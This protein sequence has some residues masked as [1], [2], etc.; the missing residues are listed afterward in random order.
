MSLLNPRFFKIAFWAAFVLRVSADASNSTNNTLL[1]LVFACRYSDDVCCETYAGAA[2]VAARHAN[3]GNGVLV[4]QFANRSAL[5]TM[6]LEIRTQDRNQYTNAYDLMKAV[7]TSTGGTSAQQQHGIIGFDFTSDVVGAHKYLVEVSDTKTPLIGW[8]AAGP[9]FAKKPLWYQSFYSMYPNDALVAQQMAELFVLK[10][11]WSYFACISEDDP[12]SSGFME[13]FSETVNG[14]ISTGDVKIPGKPAGA[15]ERYVLDHS[16]TEKNS[17]AVLQ[18]LRSRVPR[19]IVY[20][21]LNSLG[22]RTFLQAAASLNMAGREAVGG[23]SLVSV[24]LGSEGQTW[25]QNDEYYGLFTLQPQALDTTK[26]AQLRTLWPSEMSAGPLPGAP[27]G[28]SKGGATGLDIEDRQVLRPACEAYVGYVYDAVAAA[29]LAAGAQ[30]VNSTGSG[31]TGIDLSAA[32]ANGVLFDGITGRVHRKSPTSTTSGATVQKNWPLRDDISF[33][34]LNVLPETSAASNTASTTSSSGPLKITRVLTFNKASTVTVDREGSYLHRAAVDTAR[35]LD[36]PA[37]PTLKMTTIASPGREVALHSSHVEG[38]CFSSQVYCGSHGRCMNTPTLGLAAAH[39]E[40]DKGYV[41]RL[42]DMKSRSMDEMKMAPGI[43]NRVPIYVEINWDEFEHFDEKDFAGAIFVEQW[44]YDARTR[45][46]DGTWAGVTLRTLHERELIWL[47]RVVGV[48]PCSSVETANVFTAEVKYPIVR[49]AQKLRVSG[50]AVTP[51]WD[52]YPFDTQRPSITIPTAGSDVLWIGNS[53]TTVV[54]AVTGISSTVSGWQ[55]WLDTHLPTWIQAEGASKSEQQAEAAKLVA[56]GENARNVSMTHL[57]G[58]VGK[59]FTLPGVPDEVLAMRWSSTWPVEK[60]TISYSAEGTDAILGVVITRRGELWVFRMAIPAILLGT[61]AF[62]TFIV[63]HNILVPRFMSGFLAF[64]A[65]TALRKAAVDEAPESM[66][67]MNYLDV[68]LLYLTLV[69]AGGVIAV[70]VGEYLQQKY[71]SIICIEADSM[72]RRCVPPC[73]SVAVT[74]LALCAGEDNTLGITDVSTIQFVALF[75]AFTPATIWLIWVTLIVINAD[76]FFLYRAIET[77]ES[78]SASV[79]LLKERELR[80]YFQWMYEAVG[81]PPKVGRKKNGLASLQKE[82][83]TTSSSKLSKNFLNTGKMLK[84]TVGGGGFQETNGATRADAVS[85]ATGEAADDGQQTLPPIEVPST[86]RTNQ[87]QGGDPSNEPPQFVAL[88]PL[89]GSLTRSCA[90]IK[91]DIGQESAEEEDVNPDMN[92]PEDDDL[93][94]DDDD[95][96]SSDASSSDEEPEYVMAI[97]AVTGHITENI[98]T[99]DLDLPRL[100]HL[101]KLLFDLD[102]TGDN[103]VSLTEWKTKFPDVILKAAKAIDRMHPIKRRSRFNLFLFYWRRMLG[104]SRW[105]G[106]RHRHSST[107]SGGKSSAGSGTGR[108]GA[109]GGGGEQEQAK[110]VEELL[111]Y[112]MN[113]NGDGQNN[114]EDVSTILSFKSLNNSTTSLQQQGGLRQRAG[115]NGGPGKVDGQQHP[116]ALMRVDS[117]WHIEGKALASAE[118]FAE[119][120]E[121]AGVNTS[122]LLR[123]CRQ[124]LLQYREAK[125]FSERQA[126]RSLTRGGTTEGTTEGTRIRPLLDPSTLFKQSERPPPARASTASSLSNSLS[127]V[128][129]QMLPLLEQDGGGSLRQSENMRPSVESEDIGRSSIH[130]E[131]KMDRESQRKLQSD[132][133][134]TTEDA[135]TSNNSTDDKTAVSTHKVARNSD[136][137]LK[138]PFQIKKKKKKQALKSAEPEHLLDEE[139]SGDEPE[140]TDYLRNL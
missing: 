114:V 38:P 105:S 113:M 2:L 45:A 111:M 84:D 78:E 26:M 95:D 127:G 76:H 132:T 79:C 120:Y 15:V 101:T 7:L 36:S 124:Q 71:G 107:S 63:P 31:T 56:E 74:F 96:A 32:L 55:A 29:A 102:V 17:D 54:D 53:D 5:N 51:K 81:P 28:L 12:W 35:A 133:T 57:A 87:G 138:Q 60:S 62:S 9:I 14:F 18:R 34:L 58:G 11:G 21:N 48:S 20:A 91:A 42:C 103:R 59:R 77:A 139:E 23:W 116:P 30:Q 110:K 82:N 86:S 1:N 92:L 40:C 73:Y 97:G 39:C 109:G 88:V 44:Y 85:R 128:K 122:D 80:V 119:Q 37:A 24:A 118:N 130:S 131:P 49:F 68:S 25:A 123:L 13:A 6:Q 140:D 64:L 115:K 33:S 126:T 10:L 83:V 8:G 90:K 72:S 134:R 50:C 70:I 4:P 52:W 3:A 98:L 135:R 129:T 65:L 104:L 75:I 66:T 69:M 19:V 121:K 27:V 137:G 99:E 61:F 47:P 43:S 106:H 22:L 117:S 94:E 46:S 136:A 41:G 100:V 67:D 93:E 108:N 16:L 125:R 89:D 112:K